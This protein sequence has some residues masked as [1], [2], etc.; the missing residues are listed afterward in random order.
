MSY[1]AF[2]SYRRENG[3]L[4]AQCVH[5]RLEEKG[6]HCFLD[7]EELRSGQFD[8]KILFAIRE[9]HTFI[10]ILPKNALT[11]CSNEDDW[12]RK[13][14]LEAVRCHKVIVPVMYDGFKWPKKWNDSVPDE[15]KKLERMNGVSGSQ[16]YFPAMIEKILSYMPQNEIRTR[17]KHRKAEKQIAA[18]TVGF[19]WE[20]IQK[21]GD[22]ACIDMAFH[23]GHEWRHTSNKVEILN[24]ILTHGIK[25]R[26][27]ANKSEDVYTITRS[28]T[29]PLKKYRSYE[30]C[31][32]DWYELAVSCPDNVELR[33]P[34]VPLLHR[35]YLIRGNASGAVNVK[36]YTYGNY[37][38]DKDF[39]LTFE[40]GSSEYELYYREFEYL[41]N[42]AEKFNP[43]E[44]MKNVY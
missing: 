40:A 15:I 10:L 28:M 2:I 6:L 20:M 38:P 31:L 16:E 4:M 1:D 33:V 44:S 26:I 27:L 34:N 43:R 9:A 14:I 23:A 35:I 22:E 8:E 32:S 19:F 17:L 21:F 13:E 12:V 5:D 29:Q 42:N 36:Y 11:K 39:R 25:M 30:E 24:H 41:W 7:L 37:T 18:D 3:F